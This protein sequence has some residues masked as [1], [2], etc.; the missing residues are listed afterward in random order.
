MTA[1]TPPTTPTTPTNSARTPIDIGIVA[2]DRPGWN[3]ADRL[4]AAL[5][6]SVSFY[7]VGLE[8]FTS[9]G[10][11]VVRELTGRGKRV[12]LDLKL[13]DIPNTAAG[14]ARAAGRLGVELLT[15]HASGGTEMVRAAVEA[16][17][18]ASGGRTRVLAVTVLTSLAPDRLPASFRT[19]R[20][21]SAMVLDLAAESLAAGAAGLVCS[22]E[23]VAALRRHA[24]TDTLL[25]VPGTRPLGADAQDQARVVTPKAALESGADQ[26]VVGRAVTAAADPRAAWQ[27]FWHEAGI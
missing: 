18:E 9:E 19:D 13:H 12:F 3:E 7:K 23:E 20:T 17:R 4:I 1:P 10:P 21:L 15:V 24:G 11:A 25:V 6:E 22:G 27:S 2:L 8:L 26:L 5:G 14:A 16:A